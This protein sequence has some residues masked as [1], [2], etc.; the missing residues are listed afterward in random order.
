MNLIKNPNFIALFLSVLTYLIF[1]YKLISPNFWIYGSDATTKHYPLRQYFYD[2]VTKDKEFPFW[3]EKSYSGFP[4][5][6]EPETAYLNPVNTLSILFFGPSLSYKVLHFFAYLLGSFSLW[7][8]LKNKRISVFGWFCANLVYYF[9]FFLINHQIHFN[10]IMSAYLFPV[11]FFLVDRFSSTRNK[12]FLI[13]FS[14]LFV[15]IMYWGYYQI[16]AIMLIGSY[17]LLLFSMQGINKIKVV[18]KF[19]L[20]SL[21][22][23]IAASLPNILSTLDLAQHSVRD[24]AF[25][26]AEGT[27]NP[28]L[29]VNT[30]LPFIFGKF[31]NYFGRVA[32]GSVYSYTETYTYFGVTAVVFACLSLFLLE[33]NRLVYFSYSLVIFFIVIASIGVFPFAKYLPVINIFRHWERSALLGVMGVAILVS[34]FVT[35]CEKVDFKKIFQKKTLWLILVPLLYLAVLFLFT[36]N[37]YINKITINHVIP[38]GNYHKVWLALLIFSVLLPLKSKIFIF[39]KFVGTLPYLICLLI[40]IDLRYYGEDVL[41]AR[42]KYIENPVPITSNIGFEKIRVIDAKSKIIGMQFLNSNSYT[43]F[44]YSQLINK[45]YFNSLK[46]Y[47]FDGRI[48]APEGELYLSEE[49]SGLF[50]VEAIITDTGIL[51]SDRISKPYVIIKND[52][53]HKTI[54]VDSVFKDIVT[55]YRCDDDWDI[56]QNGKKLNS[57][58]LNDIFIKINGVSDEAGSINFDYV[59]KSLYLRY[60]LS[61]SITLI[62][63]GI[64]KRVYRRTDLN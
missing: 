49:L 43:I 39:T 57:G 60:A 58:C 61:F 11:A 30:L 1:F 53:Q 62:V 17:L 44:G 5:Y 56:R 45:S 50:G 55:T 6:K 22:F 26:F 15:Y 2:R 32:I 59:P 64:I 12:K 37:S 42:V 46:K 48:V 38:K 28:P 10:L 27:Y 35:N 7:S 63:L 36:R 31:Q 8:F 14:L 52:E 25:Q 51:S 33:K 40:L 13:L 34:Y 9:S 19:V 41:N 3:T 4:I 54:R 24:D 21:A 20:L 47:G 29:F 23:I 18:F 16:V